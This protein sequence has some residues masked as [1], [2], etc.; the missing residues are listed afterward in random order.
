MSKH[1]PNPANRKKVSLTTLLT[2]LVTL[3]VILTLTIVLIASY[4]SEKRSLIYTNLVQNYASAERMSQTMATLFHSMKDSL[5]YVAAEYPRLSQQPEAI[6]GYLELMRSSSNYFNSVSIISEDAKLRYLAPASIATSSPKPVSPDLRQALNIK[7]PFISKPYYSPVTGKL[8]VFMS[9]P[10]YSAD[11][12]YQGIV[13]GTLYLQEMNV[14]NM[15]FGN[16]AANPDSYYYVVDSDGYLLYH[17]DKNRIG[18]DVSRNPVV[19]KLIRGSS[20]KERMVNTRGIPMI[21]G[22]SRVAANGWG[23]VVVTPLRVVQEQLFKNLQKILIYMLIPSGILLI[24][25]TMV[26]RRLAR[27][28]VFLADL[29]GSVASDEMSLPAA[30]P[31]WNREADLL[32]RTV[33]SALEQ[34]RK[35]TDELKRDASTDPLTGLVNRRVLEQQLAGWAAA[36]RPFSVLAADIDRFKLV[37]DTL[38]H[39]AGD[40]VL[41]ETAEVLSA[42]VRPGDICCRFGGEEFIILLAGASVKAAYTVAERIRLA[43]ENHGTGYPFKVTVSLGIAAYPDHAL[44]PEELIA[45]A[46]Q[47]LYQAKELGRNRT[48]IADD[49]A[50]GADK[51]D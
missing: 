34:M 48:R 19:H 9:H 5:E 8:L 13:G 47:A 24:A 44:T 29:A 3:A 14:I 45:K 25:V 36:G 26:A 6:E 43:V 20:G 49:P 28:F 18:E 35:Q 30:R 38:G 4:Q 16:N 46:D 32:T 10:L 17:P 37:N 11:G 42:S 39:Q 7:E 51:P 2:G 23:V 41:R 12:T 21:A 15:I 1:S 33:Y 22:Y 40:T 50:G 31:H 27:P